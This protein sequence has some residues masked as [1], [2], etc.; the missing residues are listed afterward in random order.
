VR[1]AH[2]PLHPGRVAR[3]QVPLHEERVYRDE[4]IREILLE[5]SRVRVQR[6]RGRKD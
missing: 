3:L 5:L 4:E 1:Q 2:L 6:L